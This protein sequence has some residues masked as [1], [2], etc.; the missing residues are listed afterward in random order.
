MDEM[1]DNEMHHRCQ[2]PQYWLTRMEEQAGGDKAK[3]AQM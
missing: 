3:I 2:D 1:H